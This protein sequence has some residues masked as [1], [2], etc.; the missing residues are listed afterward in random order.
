MSKAITILH[1]GCGYAPYN[2]GGALRAQRLIEPLNRNLCADN[3][4]ITT[5]PDATGAYDENG[6]KDESGVSIY[7]VPGPLAMVRLARS[8]VKAGGISV[9][10]AHNA[11]LALWF[12]VV[13]P[14]VPLALELHA[15][16]ELR[17][18]KRLLF[19]RAIKQVKAVIVLAEAAKK[20]L[21]E[22]FGIPPR[23]IHVIRNGIDAV[24]FSGPD[25]T[26]QT[27]SA[28]RRIGYVGTFYRWQGVHDL[29]DAVA[30]ARQT[31]QRIQLHLV[32]HGPE[33]SALK[34][35]S[36]QLGIDDHVFFRGSMTPEAVPDFLQSMDILAL[37]RPSSVETETTV[38]LKVFEFMAS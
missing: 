31:E 3:V 37:P 29:L 7:R 25:Q 19:G 12:S 1:V 22:E 10:H 28:H 14:N 8:L 26:P 16:S 27:A 38:P 32:G 11:R 9:I 18:M 35:K 30:L 15:I 2:G 24:F 6:K 5:V 21:V 34:Q 36:T 33:T 20:Y 4:V 13:L 17:G 23:R